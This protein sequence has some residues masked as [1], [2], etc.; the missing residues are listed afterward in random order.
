MVMRIPS[1]DRGSY[2]FL[3]RIVPIQITLLLLMMSFRRMVVISSESI[4][5]GALADKSLVVAGSS[6]VFR[7]VMSC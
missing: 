6:L 7:F 3:F 1:F 2:E 4:S 5:L